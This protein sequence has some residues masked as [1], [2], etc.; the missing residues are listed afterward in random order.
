MGRV[1]LAAIVCGGCLFND[2]CVVLQSGQCR[3]H[4]ALSTDGRTMRTCAQ[5]SE[6]VASQPTL[7]HRAHSAQRRR[8]LRVAVQCSAHQPA[9]ARPDQHDRIVVNRH[10]LRSTHGHTARTHGHTARTHRHTACTHR[11]TA[12]YSTAILRSTPRPYCAVL[13]G[14]TAQY[15]TAILRGTLRCS[16]V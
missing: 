5:E 12:Q 15:S 1:G 4:C 2:S 11:H 13:H 7:A 14:H 9:L 3:G 6:S 16:A 10:A 8:P